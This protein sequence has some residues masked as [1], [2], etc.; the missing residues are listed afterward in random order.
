M[1]LDAYI[2]S[3]LFYKSEPLS[4]TELGK[5]LGRNEEEIK[6]AL[7][8]LESKLSERGIALVW[9]QEKVRLG[10][11]PEAS[12]FIENLLKEELSKDLGKA[13]LETL[14]IILYCG[15][16]TRSEI[17]FIRG[18]NSTFIVRN[19][20][21]RGLIEKVDNPNDQRSFLWRPTFEL[22]SYLGVTKVTDLPDYEEVRKNVIAFRNKE[23]PEEEPAMPSNTQL[24]ENHAE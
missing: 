4:I 8:D 23:K 16:L 10:T 12:D 11:N 21:I 14:S 6:A 9:N 5:I 22:L 2:E 24:T 13:G 20:A 3:I 19:L 7:V 1:T 18:V 15:P 17:D